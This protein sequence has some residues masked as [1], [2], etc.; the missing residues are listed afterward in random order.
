MSKE[1]PKDTGIIIALA[2]IVFSMISHNQWFLYLSIVLLGLTLLIPTVLYPLGWVWLKFSKGIQLIVSPFVFSMIFFFVVTP[3][4][5]LWRT[6]KRYAQKGDMKS[7][8]LNR[9]HRF[10]RSDLLFPY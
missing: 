9:S 1:W 7:A 3:L 5:A 6:T 8:F 10:S 4:G 2:S